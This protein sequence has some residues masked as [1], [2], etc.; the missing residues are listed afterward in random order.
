MDL[1]RALPRR[2]ANG[3]R[4]TWYVLATL[5]QLAAGQLGE[6]RT[7]V[8]AGLAQVERP[9]RLWLA[10]GMVNEAAAA[11]DRSA[12]LVTDGVSHPAPG[13]AVRLRLADAAFRKALEL[14]PDLD[15]ARLRLGRIASLS[16]QPDSTS[17]LQRVVAHTSDR[18]L[19][20][21][22][23]LFL[24][25]DA[26]RRGDLAASER[27]YEEARSTCPTCQSAVIGLSE[28]AYRG[29]QVDVARQLVGALAG[30]VSARSDDPWWGYMLGNL[31]REGA[32]R[33]LREAVR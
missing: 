20:Y 22:A 13:R 8:E 27:A 5:G 28:L 31:E 17:E 33:L 12:D 6:A 19:R 26:A 18:N 3:F 15:L 32:R 2:D 11:L 14:A 9:A 29:G 30:P 1:V 4:E 23:H 7:I 24:G 21:L 10:S 16:N 25:R